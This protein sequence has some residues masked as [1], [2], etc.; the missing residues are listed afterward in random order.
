MKK[1]FKFYL[2]VWSV[3]FV[4]FNAITFIVFSVSLKNVYAS[5]STFWLGY[6][7]LTLML[8]GNL[9]CSIIF[10]KQ[11]DLNKAFLFF[12]VLKYSYGSLIIS[13]FVST[14]VMAVPKIPF[15]IALIIDLV[16]LGVFVVSIIK[17]VAAA[18]MVLDIDEKVESST[19]FVKML[20]LDADLLYKRASSDEAKKICKK[21]YEAIRYSDPVSNDDLSEIENDIKIKFDELSTAVDSDSIEK[22]SQIG[23]E[24]L[25][26]V[27]NRNQKCK[28][29]K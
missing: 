17:P 26:L 7:F 25:L 14:F 13:A 21:V 12:P 6:S 16:L 22:V 28:L 27:S 15:W 2:I 3:A 11:D 20:T 5:D 10:F 23:D 1:Y 18:N 8:I 24:I 29:L 9:I 19:A 4:L